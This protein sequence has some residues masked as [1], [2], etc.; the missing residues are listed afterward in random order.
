MSSVPNRFLIAN[1]FA[2]DF[3]IEIKLPHIIQ[4]SPNISPTACNLPMAQ[5]TS[6]FFCY[7]SNLYCNIFVIIKPANNTNVLLCKRTRKYCKVNKYSKCLPI[8]L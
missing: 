6:G 3:S 2:V 4:E 1:G 5:R 7:L 8:I